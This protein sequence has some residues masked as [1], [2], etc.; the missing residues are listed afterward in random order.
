MLNGVTYLRP[1]RTHENPGHFAV[2]SFHWYRWNLIFLLQFCDAHFHVIYDSH[3][4]SAFCGNDNN[5]RSF[6]EDKLLQ[7]RKILFLLKKIK[8]ILSLKQTMVRKIAQQICINCAWQKKGLGC[9]H[10]ND[11]IRLVNTKSKFY[12]TVVCGRIGNLRRY[13]GCCNENVTL[14]LNFA[15]G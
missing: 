13:D 11:A 8:T 2:Q 12:P 10:E 7:C 5:L 1:R 14:K 6:L 15:L 9:F 4:L 3:R